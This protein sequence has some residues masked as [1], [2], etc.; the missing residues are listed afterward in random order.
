MFDCVLRLDYMIY[1]RD[2]SCL[3]FQKVF[4]RTYVTKWT[5]SGD[6]D[7][8]LMLTHLGAIWWGLW[9]RNSVNIQVLPTV[10]NIW[11]PSIRYDVSKKLIKLINNVTSGLTTSIDRVYGALFNESKHVYNRSR[12][13]ED[14]IIL[15]CVGQIGLSVTL[16]NKKLNWDN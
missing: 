11:V 6:S 9:V 3:A 15:R 8:G 5:Q 10:I 4:V 12:N 7:N 16:W 2:I 13:K 1:K 14:I